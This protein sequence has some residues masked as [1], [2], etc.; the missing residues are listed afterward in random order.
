MPETGATASGDDVATEAGT[1]G[2]AGTAEIA[3][4]VGTPTVGGAAGGAARAEGS[5]SG[6][7]G[8]AA[9]WSSAAPT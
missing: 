9:S 8:T 6:R 4:S 1:A 5:P 2:V 7:P 3:V